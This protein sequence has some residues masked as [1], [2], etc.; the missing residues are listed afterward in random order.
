[1]T[2]DIRHVDPTRQCHISECVAV[3][4]MRDGMNFVPYKCTLTRARKPCFGCSFSGAICVNPWSTD[5]VTDATA[6][7]N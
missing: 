1:M 4:A 7:I 5:A 3:S 6:Y 2:R